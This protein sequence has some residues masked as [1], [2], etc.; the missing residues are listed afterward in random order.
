[1]N[2]LINGTLEIAHLL[3]NY[4]GECANLHGHRLEYTV[5]FTGEKQQ[6][7]MV[8]DFKF[9][10]EIVKEVITPYDHTFLNKSF[11]NP[12]LENFS[13]QILAKLNTTYSSYRALNPKGKFS[14]L[15]VWETSKYGVEV[16]C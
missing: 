6:N 9:L 10:N 3:P 11:P 14:K 16:E 4:K 12:T 8:E 1:M 13:E 2:L 5:T 7:G 15:R